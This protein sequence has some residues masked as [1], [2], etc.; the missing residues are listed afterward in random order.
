MTSTWTRRLDTRITAPF[1]PWTSDE[2]PDPGKKDASLSLAATDI[3]FQDET[4]FFRLLLRFSLPIPLYKAYRV[5]AWAIQVA[6][7]RPETSQAASFPVK[8]PYAEFSPLREANYQGDPPPDAPCGG[9]L[10]ESLAIDISVPLNDKNR[11][12]H[13]YVTAYLREIASNTLAIDAETA[14]VNSIE[15][16]KP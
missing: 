12:P 14:F 16:T 8:D 11:G 4:L 15:R 5:P 3:S 7:E 10:G 13:I 2:R 6:I 1:T 9:F